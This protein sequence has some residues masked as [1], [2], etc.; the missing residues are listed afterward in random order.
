[1]SDGPRSPIQDWLGLV[2]RAVVLSV[3]FLYVVGLLV[4][5]IDL[6]RY[7]VTN[8][9]LARPEYIMAGALWLLAIGAPCGLVS[10]LVMVLR[11][12][13]ADKGRR[14][15]TCVVVFVMMVGAAFT[16]GALLESMSRSLIGLGSSW[17]MLDRLSDIREFSAPVL[18]NL[19]LSFL[20]I[21]AGLWTYGALQRSRSEFLA[22]SCLFVPFAILMFVFGLTVYA[23]AIFPHLP[24][25]V[26]GGKKS[27]VAIAL[28]ETRP[29]LTGRL[30]FPMSPDGRWIGPVSLVTSDEKAITLANVISVGRD[31]VWKRPRHSAIAVAR[32]WVGVIIFVSE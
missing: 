6:A 28:R 17:T 16:F 2:T 18:V 3:G 23:L 12:P 7:G 31:D 20:I 30:T 10:V 21:L 27:V 11:K 29:E 25:Y 26:G 14:V 9:D 4:V 32:D 13:W 22:Y 19:I 1:M 15:A 5:N 24:R 8:L